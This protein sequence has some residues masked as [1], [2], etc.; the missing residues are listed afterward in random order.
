[1]TMKYAAIT[2]LTLALTHGPCWAEDAKP[3]DEKTES[4]L[5]PTT[6]QDKV[7]Y[8]L[9]Y[10]LG[11]DL[12]RQQ[13]DLK[14]ELVLK[15]VE[16]AMS[17]KTPLINVWQ[18]QIALKKVRELRAQENLA[19]SQT[20]LNA[21]RYK[22]GITALPSGLQYRVIK[23]GE[24]KTPGSKDSV[25]VHYKGRLIDG[26]EFDSSYERG[27]SVTFRVG[28]VIK[29]WQEALQLMKEGS[30]WEL[31]IPPELAY[32]KR[33]RTDAIPPNSALIF[34]VELLAVQ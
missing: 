11:K 25:R 9:G 23:E 4:V 30:K 32:G 18:R 3:T 19:Q 20:F 33:G 1:M 2:V 26:R 24:G 34:E 13:L 7:L 31:Y 5:A 29:G 15:G 8:S 12:V 16:D 21:N 27:E 14:S 6:D 10:E 17:D 22:E 28:K